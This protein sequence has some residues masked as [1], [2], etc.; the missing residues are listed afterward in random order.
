MSLRLTIW[1]PSERVKSNPRGSEP[2]ARV[3]SPGQSG[4]HPGQRE[5]PTGFESAVAMCQGGL[6]G[7]GVKTRLGV[8][9]RRFVTTVSNC[10]LTTSQAGTLVGDQQLARTDAPHLE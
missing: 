2:P 1:C 5:Q 7:A 3:A 4:P 8:N 6:E 9:L 10:S